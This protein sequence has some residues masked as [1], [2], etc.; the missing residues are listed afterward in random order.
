M[1]RGNFA[2]RSTPARVDG[3][4]AGSKCLSS[5]ND[6]CTGARFEVGGEGQMSMRKLCDGV[7]VIFD[8]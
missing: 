3:K 2:V 7:G 4:P 1:I 6:K 5:S 8:S